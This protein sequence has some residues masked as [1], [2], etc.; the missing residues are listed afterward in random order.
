[1]E[2]ETKVTIATGLIWAVLA[3][4]FTYAMLRR[5]KRDRLP[6]PSKDCTREAFRDVPR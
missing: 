3:G 6:E 1:M 4:V 2:P 5:R